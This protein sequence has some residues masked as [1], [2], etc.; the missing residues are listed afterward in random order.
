MTLTTKLPDHTSLAPSP[1]V[2]R[3]L[4]P[5]RP[6][7]RLLDWAAGSLRHSRF[8]SSL[9][10]QVTAIDKL[11]N[12]T[13]PQLRR[14]Q[15]DQIEYRSCDVESGAWP[16]ASTERFDVILVTNYLFRQR[17]P[18]LGMHL[19]RDGLFIYETFAL[20]NEKFGRPKNP[21]FLLKPGE[22]FEFCQ[23]QGLHVLAFEDG[24][25][26][27]AR[28]TDLQTNQKARIQRVVAHRSINGLGNAPNLI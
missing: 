16:L 4:G 27:L 18:L 28:E 19:A 17:L 1:W 2:S 5:A 6:N 10:Y 12:E 13:L 11:P 3:W 22:L 15:S 20:G 24:I 25:V 7:S 23:R 8:A 21:D 9:G 26:D 14:D